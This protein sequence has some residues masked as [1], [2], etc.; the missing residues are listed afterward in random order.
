MAT[1]TNIQTNLLHSTKTGSIE[2]LRQTLDDIA[3]A[4]IELLSDA[5]LRQSYANLSNLPHT[6]MTEA[7]TRSFM[8][9]FGAYLPDQPQSIAC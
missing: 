4:Q 1:I 6:P 5:S 9:M 8:D 2:L 3:L 7:I